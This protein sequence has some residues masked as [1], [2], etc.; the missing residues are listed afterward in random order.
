MELYGH[1]SRGE[2]GFTSVTSTRTD[3]PRYPWP[4]YHDPTSLLWVP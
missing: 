3:T 1:I 4:A 2:R